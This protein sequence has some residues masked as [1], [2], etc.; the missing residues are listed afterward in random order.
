MFVTV[1]DDSESNVGSLG[2]EFPL[3]GFFFVRRGSRNG[4]ENNSTKFLVNFCRNICLFIFTG[5][6]VHDQ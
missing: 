1:A 5:V 3:N 4:V 6:N 2:A